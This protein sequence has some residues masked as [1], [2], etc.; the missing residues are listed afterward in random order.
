MPLGA[1]RARF[2]RFADTNV[3]ERQRIQNEVG[4]LLSVQHKYGILKKKRAAK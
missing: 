1:S 2:R 3:A 4:P